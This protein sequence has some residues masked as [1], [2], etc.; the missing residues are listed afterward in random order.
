MLA[1]MLALTACGPK[2]EAG[3]TTTA[4][5]E[6]EPQE[7]ADAEPGDGGDSGRGATAGAITT[8]DA[9]RGGGALPADSYGPTAYDL[10]RARGDRTGKRRAE[11]PGDAASGT[12]PADNDNAAGTG[13]GTPEFAAGG[14][15]APPAP[16]PII[17]PRP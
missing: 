6:G 3:G 4:L 5:E 10:A 16:V 7:P 17:V 15:A 12:A 1:L 8:I 9:A 14:G 11:D 13:A 2:P